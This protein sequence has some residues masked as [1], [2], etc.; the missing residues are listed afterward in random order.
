MRER[1]IAE[2]GL[3]VAT[4]AT[5]PRPTETDCFLAAG[6]TLKKLARDAADD[7]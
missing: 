4:L 1:D 3:N 7:G 5:E 2:D 6:S